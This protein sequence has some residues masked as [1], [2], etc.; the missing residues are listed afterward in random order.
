MRCE[1]QITRFWL[2]RGA[3]FPRAYARIPKPVS[4]RVENACKMD[5]LER[6]TTI[7]VRINN[8]FCIFRHFKLKIPL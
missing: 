3:E 5:E 2:L 8:G 6:F 7:S 1:A 4:T